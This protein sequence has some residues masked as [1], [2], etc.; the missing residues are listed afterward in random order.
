MSSQTKR[1]VLRRIAAA[2]SL[3][4][5]AGFAGCLGGNGN[6]GDATGTADG[7]GSDGESSS[8][9]LVTESRIGPKDAENSMSYWVLDGLSHQN[10]DVPKNAEAYEDIYQAWAE[11]HSDTKID[12]EVLTEYG[13]M[14]NKLLQS[15]GAGN[16]P[17]M[18]TVDCFWVPNFYG[19]L[20]P[21]TEGINNPDDFFGFVK[22]LMVQDGEWK[23]A[24][25]QTDCRAL[26]YR[27]D[28]IDKYN[29]GNP[30][31]TWDELIQVG[32]D[33][34]ENEDMHGYMYNGGRW[35]ATCFDNLA[36]YWGQ[37]GRILD[38]NRDPVYDTDENRQRLLNVFEFFKRTIDS[39]VTPQR[40]ANIDDY[41]LLHKAGFNGE[42]AMFLG[43]SFQIETM[44]AQASEE[45]VNEWKVSKIPQMES[46]MSSTGTGG[47]TQGVFQ[48]EDS[49]KP[50]I[51]DFVSRF[52]SAEGMGS[53]AKTAG[54]L[55]T[56]KSVYD[57]VDYYADDPYQQV[58]RELLE[59]GGHARP[60]G[61]V[62]Q[63]FS[64]AWQVSLQ[65]VVTGQQDPEKAVD[66]LIES[67][68]SGS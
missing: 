9:D 58:F 25:Y 8:S 5:V 46:D 31:E 41:N 12:I 17:N 35:E 65:K 56:R 45:E 7:G 63:A 33:I 3:G 19:N 21:V 24:W 42:T 62:Y 59:E 10:P 22:D 30:P 18:A 68:K 16:A 29:D 4:G 49:V 6:D 47:W 13:R 50:A 66:N 44:R 28:L 39:G 43:G 51:N 15:S 32:E 26:Y 48:A 57:E 54:A 27:Q 37:G 61:P 38:D 34:K 64:N 40:V 1:E 2:S 20:E 67:T 60:G 11:A 53:I 52:T 14:E 55:P 36:M 23:A